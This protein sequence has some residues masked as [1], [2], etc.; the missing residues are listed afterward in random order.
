MSLVLDSSRFE[1]QRQSVQGKL[2]TGQPLNIFDAIFLS[3]NYPE[4]AREQALVQRTNVDLASGRP[5]DIFEAIAISK[6]APET[7]R[8]ISLVSAYNE[9]ISKANALLLQASQQ[10][11]AGTR[12]ETVTIGK[13]PTS[14]GRQ[15]TIQRQPIL[16]SGPTLTGWLLGRSIEAETQEQFLSFPGLKTSRTLEVTAGLAANFE[17][18]VNPRTP[19]KLSISFIGGYIFGSLLLGYGIS[20][21]TEPITSPF[22]DLL[23]EKISKLFKPKEM[24]SDYLS[25]DTD[26]SL[27]EKLT[28]TQY[29]DVTKG[30]VDIPNPFDVTE[31]KT[32]VTREFLQEPVPSQYLE[33]FMKGEITKGQYVG[34]GLTHDIARPSNLDLESFMK[35]EI[36]GGEYTGEGL[37]HALKAPE[38]MGSLAGFNKAIEGIELSV[39]DTLVK[40]TDRNFVLPSMRGLEA[41]ATA[42]GFGTIPRTALLDPELTSVLENPITREIF[43]EPSVSRLFALQSVERTGFLPTAIFTAGLLGLLSVSRSTQKLGTP[44]RTDLNLSPDI[45]TFL[46]LSPLTGQGLRNEQIVIPTQIQTTIQIPKMDLPTPHIPDMKLPSRFDRQTPFD[47]KL[48]VFKSPR[49]KKGAWEK[50][51]IWEFPVKGSKALWKNLL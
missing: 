30:I 49:R 16:E 44:S 18:L 19:F 17:S 13:S 12:T 48:D 33:G 23:T 35:G 9:T 47:F 15:V 39:P 14:L 29:Q 28:P 1:S 24:P 42:T 4:A 3:H 51:Y 40:F 37:T 32:T 38:G 25:W 34:E 50:G 41:E 10:P 6:Y 2:Q 21:I 36:V 20:K 43:S 11:L 27:K 26:L 46:D 22:T 8:Q 7:A 45:A 5:P 31:G